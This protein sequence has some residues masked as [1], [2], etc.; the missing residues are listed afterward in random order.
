M[1]Q[2]VPRS[3]ANIAKE[4]DD[5]LVEDFLASGVQLAVNTKAPNGVIFS[6]KGTKKN[7]KDGMQGILST[8]YSKGWLTVTEDWETDNT[9]STRADVRGVF[10]AIDLDV[11]ATLHPSNGAC[12]KIGATY[13]LPSTL[14]A[15]TAFDITSQT[16]SAD[17]VV[18]REEGAFIGVEGVHNGSVGSC[19]FVAGMRYRQYVMSINANQ[20]MNYFSASYYHSVDEELAVAGRATLDTSKEG[21]MSMEV[22]AKYILDP[23]AFVKAKVNSDGIIGLCYSQRLRPDVILTLSGNI[24]SNKLNENSHKVGLSLAIGV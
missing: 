17:V 12:G 13:R 1:S 19:S 8:K 18:G 23:S 4:A 16:L 21:T 14:N 3:F 22:G 9:I 5:I 20:Q 11:L 15:R 7:D 2:D 6:L 10:S 24:D